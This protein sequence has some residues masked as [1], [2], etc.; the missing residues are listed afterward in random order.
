MDG[1]EGKDSLRDILRNRIARGFKGSKVRVEKCQYLVIV[2]ENELFI[3]NIYSV[4]GYY[5]ESSEGRNPVPRVDVK[6]EKPK[7]IASKKVESIPWS[8]SNVRYIHLTE[9]DYVALV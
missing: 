2:G 3:A 8:S 5:S 1:Q 9:A 6:F 4:I 7:K